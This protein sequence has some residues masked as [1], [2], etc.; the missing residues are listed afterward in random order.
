MKWLAVLFGFFILVIIVLA[1]LGRLGVLYSIYD[2]PYGDKVGHFLL[3]GI[4]TLLLDLT[5]FRA[6]PSASRGQ[7][8][9][10][11]ALL[12]AFA[13]TAEEFSQPYFSNRTFDLIDLAASYLG[14]VCF[15]WLA[16]RVKR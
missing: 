5:L 2:F 1:D 11:S 16:L 13:I 14:V 15:S 8:A 10:K 3:Y 7:V 6:V 9:V 4:L 12:L